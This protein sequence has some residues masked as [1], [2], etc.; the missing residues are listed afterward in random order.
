MRRVA[1]AERH[2]WRTNLEL[3]ILKSGMS[4]T[5][6]A[7]A[8]N[9]VGAALT[10]LQEQAILAIYRRAQ[11]HVWTENWVEHLEEALEEMGL[12]RRPDRPPA[13]AFVDISGYT[14]LTEE[15]GDQAAAELAR[16]LADLVQDAVQEH[17][18][19]MVKWLGDGVMLHFPDPGEAAE[20]TLA[21]GLR[22]PQ[23]GLPQVH[24]GIASGPVVI[25][26]GDYFGR[27]LSSR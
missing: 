4:A 2:V 18:G 23:A 27:T 15:R 5:E 9:V 11:E 24:A 16:G 6:M 13:M 3:P 17:G 21:M 1:E 25:Q 12:Y 8:T 26:D 19:R 20:G 7:H 10:P 14:R 22:T